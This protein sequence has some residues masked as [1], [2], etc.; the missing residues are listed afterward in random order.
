MAR[1]VHE[2]VYEFGPFALDQRTFELRRN[3]EPVRIERLSH[4][5]LVYLIRQR[6]RVVP[7]PELLTQLWPDTV[8]SRG[9]LA[10]TAHRT[11]DA[12]GDDACSPAWI[13]TLRGRGY[14]FVGEVRECKFEGRVPAQERV[15]P[16]PAQELARL[17]RDRYARALQLLESGATAALRRELL[18][19]LGQ[20][21]RAMGERDEASR[22][23]RLATRSFPDRVLPRGAGRRGEGAA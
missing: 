17:S 20:S 3:G 11:R 6:D 1:R 18:I 16:G 13:G 5:F 10:R 19:G 9:V 21:L 8:V 4:D 14:R 15:E 22:V 12:L 2:V 7:T 23:L